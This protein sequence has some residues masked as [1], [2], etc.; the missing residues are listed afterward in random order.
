MSSD[1]LVTVT[2]GLYKNGSLVSGVQTPI[3]VEVAFR[4]R[5]VSITSILKLDKNDYL[6]VF[7]KCSSDTASLVASTLSIT[8]WGDHR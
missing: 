3:D 2:Y 1:E 6:E 7:A 5:N 4:K 8:C